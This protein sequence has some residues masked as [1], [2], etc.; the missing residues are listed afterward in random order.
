MIRKFIFKKLNGSALVIIINKMPNY[1]FSIHEQNGNFLLKNQNSSLYISRTSRIFKYKLGIN[2]RLQ[3]IIDKYFLSSIDFHKGDVIL[4]VGANIGEVTVAIRKLVAPGVDLLS[5]SIEPDPIEF[6]CLRLNLLKSDLIFQE[7]ISNLNQEADVAYDNTSGDTHLIQNQETTGSSATEIFA[8]IRT[9]TLDDLLL[10]Q[11]ILKSIKFLKIEV[12]G[13]EPEVLLG[14]RKI[15]ERTEYVAIDCGPER[16]G[17]DTFL[18]CRLIM[19]ANGFTL[20]KSHGRNSVLFQQS[21]RG[22]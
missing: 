1:K 9:T 12:E 10:D 11:I 7:F 18:E 3:I 16:N 5:I 22:L 6:L 21:A 13:M 15:L 14:A 4:D 8:R 2:A 20:T 17:M 19:E